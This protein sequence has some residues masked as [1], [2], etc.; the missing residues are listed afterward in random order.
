[1]GPFLTH[2][3]YML[4]KR[5]CPPTNYAFEFSL[6]HFFLG[7]QLVEIATAKAESLTATQE[8][9]TRISENYDNVSTSF[10]SLHDVWTGVSTD[11]AAV[12]GQTDDLRLLGEQLV[13]EGSLTI[14]DAMKI[15]NKQVHMC[16]TIHREFFALQLLAV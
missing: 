9:L 6:L 14:I 13:G 3:C 5:S 4:K 7:I 10:S 8:T 1:M 2:A 15:K 16:C 11:I 12:T